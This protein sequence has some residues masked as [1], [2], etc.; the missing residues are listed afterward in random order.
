MS[1]LPSALA[2]SLAEA[3]CRVAQHT[4]EVCLAAE[5][6]ARRLQYDAFATSHL[7]LPFRISAAHAARYQVPFFP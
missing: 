1:P 2:E 7:G 3:C 5:G 6:L 4:K